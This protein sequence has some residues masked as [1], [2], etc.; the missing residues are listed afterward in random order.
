[1]KP[2]GSVTPVFPDPLRFNSYFVQVSVKVTFLLITVKFKFGNTL[3][4]MAEEFDGFPIVTKATFSA[5]NSPLS[6]KDYSLCT[7]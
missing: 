4:C 2:N 3:G 6:K 1:M 7:A 5:P